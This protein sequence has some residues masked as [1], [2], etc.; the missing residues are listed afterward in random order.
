MKTKPPRA[1]AILSDIHPGST[2][3]ILPPDFETLEG[4]RIKQSA[5]Q[6]WLWEAW[7]ATHQW[8]S[9][10]VNPKEY[11]LILNGD[12]TE[13]NH[14]GTKEIWSTEVG[15][16]SKAAIEILGPVARRAD[17]TFVVRGTECHVGSHEISIAKAIGAEINPEYK[18]PFWDRLRIE[19][20]G[21]VVSVRHHFPATSRVHLEAS[22]HSI[23]L[24]NAQLEALRAGEV[25]PH[26]IV[27]AH[28]HR[29][30]HWSDGK[31]MSI[32][33]GA[34]QVPTRHCFKV[35]P[36]ARPAPRIYI[37][38]WRDKRDGELPEVHFFDPVLPPAPT[39]KL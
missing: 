13:G 39:V 11:H 37:L 25:P 23:Q 31:G 9:G 20:C 17:K 35:V 26:I 30:G 14:H 10:V 38:D 2:K 8:L 5:V 24:G 12:L 33:T 19:I 22:Q 15:D 28:R 18:Q 34:W 4:Q 21:Q 36:D 3:A 7:T 32:V 1:L 6:E 16:H 29:P 27:G